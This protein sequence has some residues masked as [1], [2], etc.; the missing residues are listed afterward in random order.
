MTRSSLVLVITVTAMALLSGCA[1]LMMR[2]KDLDE[3]H[4]SVALK[5]GDSLA[6][7]ET[8][9]ET[10]IN[11]ANPKV[12]AKALASQLKQELAAKFSKKGISVAPDS[13]HTLSIEITRY[14]RGCGACRGFFPLF[15]LGNTYLDGQVTLNKPEGKRVI[16]VEKT[17]QSSGM[18]QM[19]DQTETNVDYF[20]TSV[21]SKLAS[22]EASGAEAE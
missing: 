11:K 13:E 1:G 12:D 6:I 18:S 17:G 21:A 2:V 4:A 16:I 5:S 9:L 10:S 15:G 20:A 7:D 14:E 8:A 22:A 3:Q 19:G